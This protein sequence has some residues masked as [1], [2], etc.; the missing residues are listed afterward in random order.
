MTEP[1]P[2]CSERIIP[3]I[4]VFGAKRCPK[5]GGRW[6]ESGGGRRHGS[7]TDGG[8]GAQAAAV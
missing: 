4:D 3:R 1:C 8:G 6:F 2:F 5:C 7:E